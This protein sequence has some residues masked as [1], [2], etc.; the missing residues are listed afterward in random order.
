MYCILHC[1]ETISAIAKNE[2]KISTSHFFLWNSEKYKKVFL[3]EYRVYWKA[4]SARDTFV[5]VYML[6]VHILHACYDKHVD[7]LC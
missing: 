4:K 1:I 2:N 7:R 6:I 3:Q 5:H